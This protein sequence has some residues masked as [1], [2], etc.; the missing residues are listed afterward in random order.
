MS[1]CTLVD[2]GKLEGMSSCKQHERKANRRLLSNQNFQEEKEDS[3]EEA[4][5]GR[6]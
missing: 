4:R 1:F 6:G 2:H 5:V 3:V